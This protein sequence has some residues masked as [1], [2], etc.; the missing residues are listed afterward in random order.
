MTRLILFLL[1]FVLMP[2]CRQSAENSRGV[3]TPGSATAEVDPLDYPKRGKEAVGDESVPGA[4]NSLS[5]KFKQFVLLQF[6]GR[7]PEFLITNHFSKDIVS[8]DFTLRYKDKAGQETGIWPSSRI[9]SQG[10]CQAQETILDALPSHDIPDNT[11]SVDVDVELIKFSDGTEWYGPF[12]YPKHGKEA[13][14]KEEA[15]GPKDSLAFKFIRVVTPARREF[16]GRA[17]EL[18]ITNRFSK[19][20]TGLQLDLHYLDKNGQELDSWPQGISYEGSMSYCQA[21]ETIID[22]LGGHVPENTAQ[23]RVAV[24]RVRFRDGGEWKP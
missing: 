10:W 7:R 6:H 5:F 2:G 24:E 15:P 11:N 18:L 22:A 16:S 14:G 4:K 8:V 13:V 23:V 1:I 21:G 17:A 19:D 12:K 20:I 3:R 9:D